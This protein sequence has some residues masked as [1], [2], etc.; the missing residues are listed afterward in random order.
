MLGVVA[1]AAL[2][3]VLL[4][5]R[6]LTS[7]AVEGLSMVPALDPD[8]FVITAPYAVITPRSGEIVLARDPRDRSRVLAKRV[9]QVRDDG[10]LMLLGDNPEASTDSRTFGPVPAENVIGRVVWCYWPPSRF[11]RVR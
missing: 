6:G 1:V 7:Y 8:D 4:V 9:S 10:Q 3:A 2:A 5:A 11:G